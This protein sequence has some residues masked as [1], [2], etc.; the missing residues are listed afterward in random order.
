MA[1]TAQC[2]DRRPNHCAL[3]SSAP[4][5]CGPA[6]S[7]PHLNAYFSF[8]LLPGYGSPGWWFRHISSVMT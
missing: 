7:G 8:S 6:M 3:I 1:R 5:T 4:I 2:R